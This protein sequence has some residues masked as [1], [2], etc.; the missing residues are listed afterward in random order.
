MMA[1]HN[2]AGSSAAR[3]AISIATDRYRFN[4]NG[5]AE[6]RQAVE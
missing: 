5:P 6:F 3:D 4:T 1:G 2:I